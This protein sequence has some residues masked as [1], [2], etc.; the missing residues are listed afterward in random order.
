[1]TTKFRF[2]DYEASENHSWHANYKYP[3]SFS[4]LLIHHQH[5]IIFTIQQILLRTKQSTNMRSSTLTTLAVASAAFAFDFNARSFSE[6]PHCVVCS[7]L[8]P[9]ACTG[10]INPIDTNMSFWRQCGERCVESNRCDR[11]SKDNYFCRGEAFR[12]A[13]VS[14]VRELWFRRTA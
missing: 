4:V 1:M 8:V 6:A 9:R 12:T 3:N 7:P 13:A 5:H 11:Y 10:V 2:D 14:C